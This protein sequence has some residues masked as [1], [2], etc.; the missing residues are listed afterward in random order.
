M[1]FRC[2]HRKRLSGLRFS[3][4]FCLF[5][6]FL[7]IF[8]VDVLVFSLAIYCYHCVEGKF[9]HYA[10]VKTGLFFNLKIFQVY[11]WVKNTNTYKIIL[12]FVFKRKMVILGYV[13][14]WKN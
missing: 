10:T 9:K 7:N 1:C 2:V 11:F 3:L 8:T 4:F 12:L 14:F 6:F 13:L 5:L